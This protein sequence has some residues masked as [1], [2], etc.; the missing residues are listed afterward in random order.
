MFDNSEE[1]KDLASQV[2]KGSSSGTSNDD[3]THEVIGSPVTPEKLDPKM[4]L[5]RKTT[6]T[7][8]SSASASASAAP[9]KSDEGSKAE[10]KKKEA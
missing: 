8:S 7:E 3:D 2:S 1:D 5:D 9:V 4:D 6:G 10:E